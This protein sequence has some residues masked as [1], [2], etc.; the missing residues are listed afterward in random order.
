MGNGQKHVFL[1]RRRVFSCTG[2]GPGFVYRSG[3]RFRAPAWL[4]PCALAGA[5]VCTVLAQI[6]CRVCARAGPERSSGALGA[7]SAVGTECQS[8]AQFLRPGKSAG[9][10]RRKGASGEGQARAR[11]RA[12]AVLRARHLG[13]RGRGRHKEGRS[14]VLASGSEFRP[15]ALRWLFFCSWPNRRRFC[16]PIRWLVLFARPGLLIYAH[17]RWSLA[18]CGSGFLAGRTE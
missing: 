10:I 11:T 8:V 5:F 6:R 2:L 13:G 18:K 16:A 17:G 7:F 4:W 3:R 1:Y 14:R 15:G 12:Q 9:T